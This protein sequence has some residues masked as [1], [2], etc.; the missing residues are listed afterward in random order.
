ML[1]LSSENPCLYEDV[2]VIPNDGKHFCWLSI[3]SICYLSTLVVFS[4]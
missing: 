3:F 1:S 4:Q 2:H